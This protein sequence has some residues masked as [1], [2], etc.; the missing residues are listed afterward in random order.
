M[1]TSEIKLLEQITEA[2]ESQPPGMLT[3]IVRKAVRLAQLCG[4]KE[5]QLLFEM[6]LEDFRP[7]KATES[8]NEHRRRLSSNARWQPGDVY[9]EDWRTNDGHVVVHALEEFERNLYELEESWDRASV[10][11]KDEAAFHM[12]TEQRGL[13]DRM[14]NRLTYFVS[15]MHRHMLSMLPPRAETRKEKQGRIFIAHGRSSVWRDLRDLLAERLQLKWE[16][17]NREPAA[18]LTTVERLESMLAGASFAFVVMSAEDEH[19]DGTLHARENVIHEAGLFQGRLGFRRAIILVEDGC[20]EFSNIVGLSQI[21]FPSGDLLA[22]SE[23]IR[24]VLEREEIIPK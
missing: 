1:L 6:Y 5:F 24:R 15:E 14:R 16:E 22:K 23:E 12:I 2:L 17:F 11:D 3:P 9:A 4:E 18:G 21:R 13:L 19:A 20:Q 10:Y 7:G 8:R